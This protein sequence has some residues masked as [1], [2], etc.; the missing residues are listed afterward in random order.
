MSQADVL[1]FLKENKDEWFTVKQIAEKLNI[2]RTSATSNC[3]KLR[4][5][6]YIR[7]REIIT[8][9]RVFEYKYKNVNE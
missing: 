9:M 3:G 4:R 8:N 6:D 7:F 1:K 2:G 5:H